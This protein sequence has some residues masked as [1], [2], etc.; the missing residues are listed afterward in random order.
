M[1]RRHS[2]RDPI[3]LLVITNHPEH[4]SADEEAAPSPQVL[5]IQTQVP[6]K[7]LAQPAALMAIHQAANVYGRIP[8]FFD[9]RPP[10][11]IAP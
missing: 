7:L 9:G 3:N 10:D 1:R 8:Q 6:V 2:G 4:Y 11:G 5:S